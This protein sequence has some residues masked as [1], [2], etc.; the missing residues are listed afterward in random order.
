MSKIVYNMSMSLD[1]FVTSA[2]RTPEEPLGASG[3][4][5]HEWCVEGSDPRNLA[6]TEENAAGLGAMIT[7][8]QTY[9][10]SLPWWG[11]DGP[12]GA[13]RIPLFVLTHRA[14]PSPDP[15]S[16]YEFVTDG[17]DSVVK[18]AKAAAGDKEI[19]V[20]GV[21]IGR[22]L[23]EAGHLDEIWIHITPLLFGDGTR[24]YDQLGADPIDLEFVEA[25][26]THEAVHL[27]YQVMP[28][29]GQA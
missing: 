26:A 28:S 29:N 15:E 12:A 21:E 20:S 8:R 19:G 23:L 7:G 9:D 16:V 6:L 1:G 22:L 18:Q 25:V 2:G 3:E 24:L 4:R 11:P 13:A 27:R 17:V 14:E 5:L 10:D